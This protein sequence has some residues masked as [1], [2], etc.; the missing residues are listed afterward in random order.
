MTRPETVWASLSDR[1][2]LPRELTPH[3][4]AGVAEYAK[5]DQQNQALAG[6]EQN[7]HRRAAVLPVSGLIGG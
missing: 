6:K 4:L 7:R 1:V 2:G 3:S 5:N